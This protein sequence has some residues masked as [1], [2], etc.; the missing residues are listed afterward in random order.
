MS[1]RSGFLT[2]ILRHVGKGGVVVSGS[3]AVGASGTTPTVSKGKGFSVSYTATGKY[4]ITFDKSFDACVSF[5]SSLRQGTPTATYQLCNTLFTAATSSA[6]AYIGVYSFA[7]GG[8]AAAVNDS[9]AII[10]FIAVFKNTA[11]PG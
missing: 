11:A 5:V 9:T 10:D 4:V 7:T 8:S 6:Q 3:I 2:E 1:M